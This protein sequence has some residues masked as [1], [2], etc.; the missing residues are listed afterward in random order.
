MRFAQDTVKRRAD[1]VCATGRYI[2][3]GR[4][5]LE[6]FGALGGVSRGQQRGNRDDRYRR[7]PASFGFDAFDDITHFLGFLL[8]EHFTGNN[9]RAKR[10]NTCAKDHHCDYVAAAVHD[11]MRALRE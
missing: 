10:D 5:F 4:A 6:D 7:F 11:F 9:R 3:A 8:F 1:T 2:V